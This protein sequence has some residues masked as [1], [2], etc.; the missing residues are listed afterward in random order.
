M[1]S[2]AALI[3]PRSAP[4][5]VRSDVRARRRVHHGP[6]VSAKNV[7]KSTTP[8]LSRGGGQKR[9][10]AGGDGGDP[11]P[12]PDPLQPIRGANIDPT[13]KCF[14]PPTPYTLH[15]TPCTLHP[16]P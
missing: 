6:V 7:A 16:S 1:Y 15:P 8:S 5:A 13:G 14:L 2:L 9:A 10:A 4:A 12:R 3:P 11:D